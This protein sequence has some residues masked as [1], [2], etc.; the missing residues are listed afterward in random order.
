MRGG[1]SREDQERGG[2]VEAADVCRMGAR[3]AQHIPGEGRMTWEWNNLAAAIEGSCGILGSAPYLISS[4]VFK[5]CYI[6]NVGRGIT[7]FNA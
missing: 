3:P 6:R 1:E 2:I 5:N 4:V 7:F